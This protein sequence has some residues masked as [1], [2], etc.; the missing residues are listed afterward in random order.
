MSSVISLYLILTKMKKN[1]S[2][3][4]KTQV[5]FRNR[6]RNKVYKQAMKTSIKQFLINIDSLNNASNYNLETLSLVYQSIDKAVKKGVIHKN[7]GS[8]KKSR[9]AKMIKAC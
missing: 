3:V 8:R 7:N 5:S 4:K 6:L 1:L 2:A 9:L